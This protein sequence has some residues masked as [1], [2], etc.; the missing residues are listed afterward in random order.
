MWFNSHYV[1]QLL[2]IKCTC[3]QI[4][5]DEPGR[6]AYWFDSTIHAREWL[7]TATN[8]Y[9]MD[10]VSQSSI[11][12]ANLISLRPWLCQKPFRCVATNLLYSIDSV[13]NTSVFKI[14]DQIFG[15]TSKLHKWLGLT[16]IKKITLTGIYWICIHIH[17]H[18][19][20]QYDLAVGYS[21]S[22]LYPHLE[23]ALSEL[24]ASLTTIG[25]IGSCH[26]K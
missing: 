15:K 24:T 10:S 20:I 11:V 8:L 18:Y 19:D 25:S 6:R 16:L 4:S 7:A 3:F 17:K 13:R 14:F 23:D 2:I 5:K 22:M 9:V 12:A 1:L 26:L 21:H